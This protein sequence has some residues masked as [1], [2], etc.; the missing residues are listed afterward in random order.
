MIAILLAV[1]AVFLLVI[2]DASVRIA[3]TLKCL[4]E[5]RRKSK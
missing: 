3:N 2:A 1:I 5:E 4:L